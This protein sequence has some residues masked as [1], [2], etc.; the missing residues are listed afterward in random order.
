[1]LKAL[2][3]QP[4]CN[5]A[6]IVLKRVAH[7]VPSCQHAS[8]QLQPRARQRACSCVRSCLPKAQLRMSPSKIVVQ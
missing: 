5:A 8:F 7:V 6:S 2:G 4:S 3:W 1:M